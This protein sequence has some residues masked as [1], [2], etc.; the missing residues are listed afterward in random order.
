MDQRCPRGN[1]PV[2]TTVAK[3]QASATRDPRDEP[4]ATRDEPS[5]K[6]QNPKLFHSHS[7][8]SHSSRS[9]DGETSDKEARKEQKKQR[10]LDHERARKDSGSTP[11][12]G[13]NASGTSG[14]ARKDLSQV[15]YYNCNEKGHYSRNCSE[16]ERD[17]SED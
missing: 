14:G 1:R 16:S 3:F 11:A 17:A 10:R 9:E 2:H 5:E 15:T 7:S 12:T 4:S 13:V 8:R 6:V